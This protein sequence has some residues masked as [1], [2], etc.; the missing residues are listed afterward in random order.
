MDGNYELLISKINEF[1]RKFYL[2]KLLRGIIYTLSILAA[3]YLLLF[4][5]VYYL[6]PEPVIKTILFFSYLF[7]LAVSALMGIVKPGLAFF[8]LSK[9]ISLEESAALIGDH[10][11]PVRDKL[12]NTLQLKALADLSPGQ[13]QLILAGID[14]KINELKPVPFS[15][16]V[17]LN[18]NKKYIKYFLVPLFLILII[19]ITAPVVLREGT[20][21]FI[22]YNKE[23]LPAAPFDFV[24]RNQGLTVTQGDDLL[25]DLELKG[26][27]LP[28]EVYIR[29]GVNTFKLERKSS[30]RFHY[31]FKNLQEDK[32]LRFSAGG[33]DSR[34]YQLTVKPRPSVLTVKALLVYPAYLKKKDETI[35]NTGDLLIPE[36]T[37]VT[38]DIYTENAARVIFTLGEHAGILNPLHNHSSFK[39]SL[40]KSQHYRIVPENSFSSH[41]D[42]IL[43]QIEVVPDLPPAISVNEKADSLSSKALYFTGNISDDHGFS[44]LRFIYVLKEN[45][46][47]KKKVRVSLP[48]RPLQQ[49]NQ[50]F[51]FWNLRN[52]PVKAGQI[53]EY[54]LEVADNDGVNGP[55][56]TRSPIKTYVP[57]SDQQIAKQLNMQSATLKQKM[58]SAIKL[59]A[60]VEKESKKL[61]E[62]LLDKKNLSFENKKEIAQL[63]DKQKKLEDAVKEIQ[64]AKKKNTSDQEE[65][66]A[67]KSDL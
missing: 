20:S 51:Y 37:A 64:Q 41:P 66:E 52:V 54:Y 1:T 12:L 8:R 33:Y 34:A 43:H 28:Q 31:T 49:E 23:V 26:D 27:L 35:E 13:N 45:G 21:S 16:A 38:W 17:N 22:Q 61:G 7:I 48:F 4:I 53:L 62:N 57:P 15:K 18:D 39:A 2:N 46:A 25:L 63:L 3:L 50:F 11:E 65:N 24:L 6:R 44:S 56:T 9:T 55:K 5:L 14:Q 59:A 47:E 36:G 42:S 19:A 10:F 60:E 40:K 67:L 58:G 32:I 29:E 30:S